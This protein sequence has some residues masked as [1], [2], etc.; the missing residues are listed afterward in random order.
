MGANVTAKEGIPKTIAEIPRPML[1]EAIAKVLDLLETRL[2]RAPNRAEIAS[3]M[4]ALETISTEDFRLC[5]GPGAP[6][7]QLLVQ[8]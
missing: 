4:G 7:H 3:I 6:V 2:K 1:G 5:V 8:A